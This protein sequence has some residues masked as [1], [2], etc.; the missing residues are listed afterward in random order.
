AEQLAAAATAAR[1]RG[2]PAMAAEIAEGA[3]DRTPPQNAAEAAAR[4]YA[5]A[6]HAYAAGLN[7]DTRRLAEAALARAVDPAIRVGAP[8]LQRASDLARE[9]A[10]GPEVV[11]TRQLCAMLEM[12]NGNVD[13]AVREIDA[14]RTAVQRAGTVRDLSSVLSSMA[15][16]YSRA[17]KCA[18]APRAG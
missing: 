15:S 2:A 13:R 8:L 1:R 17:G 18:Q 4:R 5:A 14:L 3:A 7:A 6:G 10:P 16:V 9:L 11:R 12:F